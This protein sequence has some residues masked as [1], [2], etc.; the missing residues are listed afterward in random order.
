MIR[1]ADPK[2]FYDG[3]DRRTCFRCGAEFISTTGP[4]RVCPGCRK[5]KN[6]HERLKGELGQRLS[7]RE[8]Q[9]IDLVALGREN[10]EIAWELA[11]TEG[12]I[13]EYINRIFQKV[14]VDNRTRLARW[15]W[16]GDDNGRVIV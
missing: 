16:L 14:G 1:P 5:P 9:V 8:M 12:T 2:L 10:K 6:K 3:P 13:K 15:R 4:R 11:L 7:C